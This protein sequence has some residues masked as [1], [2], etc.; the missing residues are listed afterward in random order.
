MPEIE[1]APRLARNVALAAIAVLA[2]TAVLTLVVLRPGSHPRACPGGEEWI[3]AE[4][5]G[6]AMAGYESTAPASTSATTGSSAAATGSTA[7]GAA[8]GAAGT[9]TATDPAAAVAAPLLAG[10]VDTGRLHP[11]P[12]STDGRG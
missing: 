5:A 12:L 3:V 11:V 8:G 4:P 7:G 1:H 9:A 10:C 6:I 2:T